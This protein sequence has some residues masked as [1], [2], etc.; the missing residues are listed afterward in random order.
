MNYVKIKKPKVGQTYYSVY[1]DMNSTQFKYYIKKFFINKV[2]EDKQVLTILNMEINTYYDKVKKCSIQ[3]TLV[4]KEKRNHIKIESR[5]REILNL[6]VNKR[7]GNNCDI[8]KFICTFSD[9]RKAMNFITKKNKTNIFIM[10]DEMGSYYKI[11]ED[12]K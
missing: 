4:K 7:E 11:I 2:V 10:I 6:S 9:K 3:E 5:D 12:L 1:R 8:N